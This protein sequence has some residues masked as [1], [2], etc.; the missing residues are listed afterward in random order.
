MCKNKEQRPAFHN[1]TPTRQQGRLTLNFVM[2]KNCRVIEEFEILGWRILHPS[3]KTKIHLGTRVLRTH[4]KFSSFQW[5]EIS[6]ICNA[7]S[8][9]MF[10]IF[11]ITIFL[12]FWIRDT[13]MSS[14]WRIVCRLGKWF[15]IHLSICECIRK[16]KVQWPL[17]C[18]W[19]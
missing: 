15:R 18:F 16:K 3:F 8:Q 19:I 4:S 1:L 9:G 17:F 7:F 10:L 11:L 2:Q 14:N 12:P 13:S 5:V 6:C